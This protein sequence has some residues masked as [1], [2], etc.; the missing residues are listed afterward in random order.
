MLIVTEPRRGESL[1]KY[2]SLVLQ[3]QSAWLTFSPPVRKLPFTTGEGH[4]GN[5]RHLEVTPEQ[6]GPSGHT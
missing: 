3:L 2:L 5:S 4:H 6:A 1:F